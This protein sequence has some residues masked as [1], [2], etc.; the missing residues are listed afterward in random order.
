METTLHMRTDIFKK[1]T[2]AA[3]STGISRSEMIAVLI[4]KVMDDISKPEIFGRM[5][6][7]QQRRDKGEW[8]TFHL[9]VREDDCNITFLGVLLRPFKLSIAA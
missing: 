8:H 4:K 2:L 3:K 1:I 7:Y 9:Y 5:V 6:Q